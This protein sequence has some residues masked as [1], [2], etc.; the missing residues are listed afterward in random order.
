MERVAT[1][2]KFLRVGTSPFRVKGTTYGTFLPRG[3]GLRFPEQPQIE[4]DL[5]AMAEC[6]F[7]TVRVYD[8][9]PPE[10]LDGA[11]ALG[12]RVLV[13]LGYPDWRM[14]AGGSARVHRLVRAA[15]RACVDEALAALAGRPEVLAVSVGNEVPSDVT[16]LYGRAAIEDALSELVAL[17]HEGDPEMLAT[18]TGYPTAEFLRVEGQDLVTFNVFLERADQLAPYLRHLQ[19]V[20]ADRP[21]VLTEVGLAAELHGEEEQARSLGMQLGLV[22]E[23][24]CAGATIF[25]WTDEWATSAGPVEGWGF[26]LT[27]ADRSPRPA[28]AVASQWAG[29][30]VRDLR[31]SWPPVTA[32]VCAYNEERRIGGCLDSLSGVDYPALQVVVCDDGS[33]DTT[34]ELARRSP[35]EVL[36][37]PHG[38]LSA[39]RNA[40]LAAATGD[41]VA[42]L[43]AD[44]AC[45]PEWPYH[46]ALAFEDPRVVVAGGPNLPFRESGLVERAVAQSPGGP[47]EVLIGD[48]RAEHVPGCNLAVRRS[49]LQ[50]IGGFDPAYTTAGDDVDVCWRLLDLGGQVAFSPA[51]QVRHHR[52][53][54]VR[55]YL[56]QQRGYG[57]AERMLAGQHRHRFNR[58]GAAKWSGFVY[59]GPR[60]LPRILKPVVYHGP[61]GLAPY[62]TEIRDRAAPVVMWASAVIPL[63]VLLAVLA[64]PFAVVVPAAL[65]VPAGVGLAL[66]AYLVVVAAA[67]PAT[68][69]ESGPWRLRVL[70]GAL[71][72]LQPLART[73]GRLTGRPLPSRVSPS[74]P[75]SGSRERWLA[76]LD[77]DLS[78]HWCGVRRGSPRAS[79]DI[80]I[81][82]GPVLRCRL[83]LAVLW[84]W[85]PVTRR[86]WSVS[87]LGVGLLVAALALTTSSP[88]AGAVVVGAV[89]VS[90]ALEAMVLTRLSSGAVARTTRSVR[91]TG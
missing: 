56:R 27:R 49:A 12:M 4:R 38:G 37:L 73:W 87:R 11:R 14:H 30:T 50:E 75:W 66:A 57:R 20:T 84:E 78:A 32:V 22:D 47:V 9:P 53:D 81:G 74:R 55:G 52:R 82:V 58:W 83:N 89:L 77:Q 46:L 29:R 36:A 6:G 17:V 10:L 15:G 71:H 54:T 68:P 88:L 2:G 28:L 13:G 33:T 67:T 41:I 62:Q 70:V 91:D 76:A 8:L 35:F 60:I 63:L 48:D 26:G 18:Y 34:L 43:D 5:I 39:A 40:G 79:W 7:T 16:R 3:D 64:L 23:C 61:M 1:D 44:A 24:G 72:V 42:Y 31:P 90:A 59:G 19:R 85:D 45:H 80:E 65:L 51:A 86:T 25:S 69:G 21:L